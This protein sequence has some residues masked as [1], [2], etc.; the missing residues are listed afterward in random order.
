M[1]SATQSANT[2]KPPRE[3]GR[4]SIVR[5]RAT[6]L[7]A[8]RA[9]DP[10]GPHANSGTS[11]A[12]VGNTQ[13]LVTLVLVIGPAVGLAVVTSLLWGHAVNLTDVVMGTVLYVVTGF[14]V[15]VGYHRLFTH[16]GFAPRR[17]LKVILAVVGSMA[18]EG[19]V[20]S[21]VATHRRHHLYSDQSG[22]PHSPHRYGGHR[23]ALLRGLAFA[24][25]GWLFVSDASSAERYAPDMLRDADMRRVGQLFPLLAISSLA[26]PF[27][28][29]YALAG[30]LTGAIT[31]LVWAGLVRMTLLHHV[32]WSVSSLCHAFGRRTDETADHSRN[33]WLLAI[34]SLGES[35]HNIH[36]AHPTWARHGARQGMLDPSARLIWVFSASAGSTR[37][38]G[39]AAPSRQAERPSHGPDSCASPRKATS[40]GG[41]SSRASVW[42]PAGSC[43]GAGPIYCWPGFRC[44][45]ERTNWSS[46]SFGGAF[47]VTCRIGSVP[48]P[49]GRIS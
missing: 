11:Q 48:S 44:S 10:L 46:R 12:V 34:P 19:S 2:V 26:L 40:S 37:C 9:I 18:V 23:L 36:H 15:T 7:G 33:L 29:G 35:W 22:D 20:T 47:E 5:P 41:S 16:R 39:P 8:G 42:T 45:S 14:G 6:D 3:P 1:S 13:K 31:A 4:K 27:G 25:V 32:T 28:I 49:P 17:F 43:G 24:H 38:G 21:W 30:T